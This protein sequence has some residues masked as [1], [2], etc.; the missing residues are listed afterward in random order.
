MTPHPGELSRLIGL[1]VKDIEKQRID[2]AMDVAKELNTI[3]VLKGVP[4][5]IS[6]G[7]QVFVNTTGNPGMA[8]GGSGDVLTGMISSLIGQGVNVFYA[9]ILGVYL[10]GLSGDIGSSEKGYH[11]LIARDIIENIPFAIKETLNEMD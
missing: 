4:T 9:S 6:D 7:N 8:T 3:V 11:G 10:H 5:V 1:S 2:I